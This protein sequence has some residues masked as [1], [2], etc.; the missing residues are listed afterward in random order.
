[1]APDASQGKLRGVARLIGRSLG[2]TKTTNLGYNNLLQKLKNFYIN[3]ITA[4]L[5]FKKAL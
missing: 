2:H 1:M 4:K 3:N 5:F